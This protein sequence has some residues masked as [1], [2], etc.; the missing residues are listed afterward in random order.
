[1]GTAPRL[2]ISAP[3]AVAVRRMPTA[4]VARSADVSLEAANAG[5]HAWRWHS[6][7]GDGSV[8]LVALTAATTAMIVTADARTPSSLV[9][10]LTVEL[11]GALE[12]TW[13]PRVPPSQASASRRRRVRVAAAIAAV[14]VP[15]LAVAG[16]RVLAP[17][18]PLDV[19]AA[20]TQFRHAS[21]SEGA[22]PTSGDGAAARPVAAD[23]TAPGS[24]PARARAKR[25]TPGR[26]AQVV[27]AAQSGSRGDASAPSAAQSSASG[28][29]QQRGAA[30]PPPSAQRDDQSRRAPSLP[31]EGVYRYATQ[32]YESIDQ[33]SSRHDYPSETALTIR[34]NDCGFVAHWQPLENRWDEMTIC[35]TAAGSFIPAMATHREFY[36]QEKDSR[37]TCSDGFYA[38]RPAPGATWTGRCTDE[39]STM[40]MRG[41][42]LGREPVR[43]GD[44]TVEAVHYVIEARISGDNDGTWRAERWIDPD[45]GLL[46]R[47]QAST[48]ATSTSSFGTV[49]YREQTDVRL[50]SMTPQR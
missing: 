4:L 37:Y 20:V 33:P 41:R 17:P 15:A 21:A 13:A 11:S 38:Y 40:Q 14:L 48:D 36:G 44:Q 39:E 28:K 24:A 18:A 8:V 49:R 32:G 6:P 19:A 50:L 5:E 34:H 25:Q 43:V 29:G 7:E 16:S 31:P 27:T 46:L 22:R 47:A 23:T 10:A 35:R 1:M 3:L 30:A 12:R 42:T 26:G 9:D 45:S 2:T